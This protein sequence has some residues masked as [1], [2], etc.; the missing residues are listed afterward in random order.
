[1]KVK[2]SEA[3][4]GRFVANFGKILSLFSIFGFLFSKNREF[5]TEYSFSNHFLKIRQKK[6][7]HWFDLIEKLKKLK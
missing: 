6:I 1:M 2:N 7:I 5:T 4:G 3:A